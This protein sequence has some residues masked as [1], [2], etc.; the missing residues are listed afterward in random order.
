MK[1]AIT[2][3]VHLRTES[4]TPYRYAALE[5]IFQKCLAENV[6][7]VFIL[8][9]LFDRDFSNYHD[10]DRLCFAY[11]DLKI[12]VLPGNHDSA[13]TQKSFSSENLRIIEK[14][15]LENFGRIQALFIP[16]D[17]VLTLDEAL[18]SYMTEN[19]LE[20]RFVLFGHGDW[21]SSA[22]VINAYE[23]GVYMP[24]TRL[25]LEKFSPL[26]IFLGHIHQPG[27]YDERKAAVIY[28]GSP[29]G[30]DIN[31]TGK[32]KFLIYDTEDDHVVTRYVNTPV[33][34][35][36]ETLLVLPIDDEEAWVKKK[37]ARMVENW[38]VTGEDLRKVRLRL[39]VKGFTKDKGQLSRII[40][41]EVDKRGM[42]F[43]D[44]QG[45]DLS[46]LKVVSDDAE[47][48]ILLLKKMMEKISQTNLERFLASADDVLEEA[49]EIIFG[50]G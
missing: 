1:I 36:K 3:D 2:A 37:I 9:D 17:P 16:Y 24:L 23:E 39:Q 49:G 18:Q 12:T 28:P 4:E 35:F 13:L 21:L 11:R 6:K 42:N 10:F 48:K 34:Y 45:A 5:N 31:E 41:E 22:R 19:K 47:V 8:G 32:R 43:H 46:D 20:R 44:P 33:I 30:L 25:S 29:C 40:H 50:M 26:R 27:P 14:P 38:S 7:D 15:L